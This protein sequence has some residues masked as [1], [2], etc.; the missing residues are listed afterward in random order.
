MIKI[1]NK[2]TKMEN[3]IKLVELAKKEHYYVDHIYLS[4][5]IVTKIDNYNSDEDNCNDDSDEDNCNDDVDEIKELNE[6]WKLKY[7]KIYHNS[8]GETN[9]YFPCYNDSVTSNNNDYG[10]L[11]VN[12]ISEPI[13][14]PNDFRIICDEIEKTWENSVYERYSSIINHLEVK[15]L[16][17]EH[18]MFV[19]SD[20]N[21]TLFFELTTIFNNLNKYY[22]SNKK[23]H[24]YI[25]SRV[26]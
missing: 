2:T 11:F 6:L 24:D 13:P 8:F 9:C 22:E 17:I 1:L 20:H 7:E 26:K 3:S 5:L 4:F 23:W 12:Y 25:N 15:L 10:I 14:E 16:V 18:Y 19:S 21:N